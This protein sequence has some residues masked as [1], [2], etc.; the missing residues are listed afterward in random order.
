MG[1]GFFS[2]S[3][4]FRE[5]V[6]LHEKDMDV[7]LKI[8]ATAK[9]FA[10]CKK[11]ALQKKSTD[12]CEETDE[13]TLGFTVVINPCLF[14][15]ISTGFS[16]AS[17]LNTR[18]HP[19]FSLLIH[20][21]SNNSSWRSSDTLCPQVCH[22]HQWEKGLSVPSIGCWA[23]VSWWNSHRSSIKNQTVKTSALKTSHP[24]SLTLHHALFQCTT[25]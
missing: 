16:P 3:F 8:L 19:S 18:T 20:Y 7:I 15:G 10:F 1:Q 25:V 11:Q 24:H 12:C 21:Q 2:C 6:K 5:N 22:W 23:E 13:Q 14:C 17:A 9:H 4:L